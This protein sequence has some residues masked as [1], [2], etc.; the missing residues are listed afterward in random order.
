MNRRYT[1]LAIILIIL[2]VVIYVDTG[3]TIP[4][5]DRGLPTVL[6]LDLRGGTQALLE[7]NLPATTDVT[8][9]Q[10]ADARQILSNRINGLGVSESAVQVAGNRR[11]V[12]QIPGLTDPQQVINV[13]KNTGQLEFVD[14]GTTQ[15]T[16]GTTIKTDLGASG[17]SSGTAVPTVVPT[18]APTSAAGTPTAT[19]A[20]TPETIWHTVMT[21]DQLS[22]VNVTTDQLGN[23]EISFTLKSEGAQTFA[24]YTAANVGKI[25]AIVL[26]KK[27]ISAPS[28]NG[29]IPS[30][31]GVIQGKFT[32]DEANN[33]AVQMR[34][35]SLPV[36]L[37]V[38]QSQVI[39]P[40]LGADSL[41]KSILAGVIGFAIVTLFMIIYYRLPGVVA[42]LSIFVYA[43]I[44]YAIYKALAVTLTLPGIVG[45][46]LS[47]GSAM[48]ANILI[49][50]RMKEEL[51]AGRSLGN[52]IELGWRRA[53]PSIRDSNLATFIT[54]WI[55]IWFGSTYGATV[56]LGFAVT[57]LVGIVVS[58]FCAIIVTRTFLGLT[59]NFFK[60]TAERL[61]WFG[62]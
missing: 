16:V 20:A 9:S 32:V 13:I 24:T 58:L 22:S 50:E 27:I 49:F 28:I 17:T 38:V 19:V 43:A 56:V 48:D 8:A 3:A 54:C 37:K 15:L 57:L 18:A 10:M 29:A 30:G 53:W 51:R 62:L 33:L 39:G 45:F 41:S 12:V 25:L 6:G 60:S 21:G 7:V 35:G 47:T 46:L 44:T 26:D 52:A 14:L 1:N 36:P 23:P 5:L 61:S 40:S 2:I 4:F 42:M 59:I 11:M 55:L 31:Q 34:Y